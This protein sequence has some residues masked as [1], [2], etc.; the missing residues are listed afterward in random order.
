MPLFFLIVLL[1]APP[2][3]I[4][5]AVRWLF[6][7][8]WTAAA[9]LAATAAVGALLMKFAKIGVGEAAN[10]LRAGNAPP[11]AVAGFLK[12]WLVGALLFFP[13]Y[14][15]DVLAAGALLLPS[16]KARFNAPPADAPLEARAEIVH[17]KS[18][19]ERRD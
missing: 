19:N 14:L 10:M 11:V 7:S 9:Y 5:L 1:L 13:G 8:P 15:S 17:E 3:D 12:M 4:F 16:P 6:L 18:E 2:L